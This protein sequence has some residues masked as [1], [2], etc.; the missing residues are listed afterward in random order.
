MQLNHF[1]LLVF[2]LI[3]YWSLVAAVVLFFQNLSAINS[4]SLSQSVAQPRFKLESLQAGGSKIVF[5][6]FI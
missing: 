1:L 2:T 6:L 4:K 5:A 3:M